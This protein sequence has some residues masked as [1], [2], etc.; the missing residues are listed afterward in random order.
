MIDA[1][2][3]ERSEKNPTTNLTYAEEY[4]ASLKNRGEDPAWVD[5]IMA[6]NQKRRQLITEQERMRSEQNK[7]GEEIA[8]RKR[9]KEDASD[10]LHQMQ[11]LAGQVKDFDGKVGEVE[12]GAQV[13][14]RLRLDGAMTGG[15]HPVQRGVS[16][17]RGQRVSRDHAPD[18]C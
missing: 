17:C 1:R 13:L 4:R 16:E 11:A 3:L 7:V 2:A 18:D 8:R 12:V 14:V 15:I 9:A 6:I 5:K 10:L